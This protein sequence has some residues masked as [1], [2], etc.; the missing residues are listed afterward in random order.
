MEENEFN[1]LLES[2]TQMKLIKAGK[3][4][5]ARVHHVDPLEIRSIRKKLHLSQNKFAAL[6]GISDA[7]LKN[8]E[9]G[10][11]Q[12]DG[13]ARVLLQVVARQPKAVLEALHGNK[14]GD[15]L[16]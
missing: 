5:P 8:W 15:T 6:I 13:S 1:K 11:V 9:Q 4:K 2:V 16:H 14:S 3:M 10:R 12:P 7:T